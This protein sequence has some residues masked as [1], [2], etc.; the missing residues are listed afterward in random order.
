M[1][2]PLSMGTNHMLAQDNMVPITTNNF[3]VRLFNLDGSQPSESNILTLYT[4][5]IGDVQEEQDI[6]SVHYGNGVQKFPSKVTFADVDWTLNYFCSPNVADAIH[7]WRE[8]VFEFESQKMGL[9]S[10]Y[11]K[12][13]YFIRYD[14]QGN[15][16]SIIYLPCV[17][18]GAVRET[19]GNQQ[20]GEVVKISFPLVV[21]RMQYIKP[22]DYRG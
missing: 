21:S 15:P 4:D 17:W 9:P 7:A 10:Q 16:R 3:E 6:I 18:P 2:T 13:A 20:G 8:K 22:E 12:N 1:F 11:M 5:E 19:G 14:G